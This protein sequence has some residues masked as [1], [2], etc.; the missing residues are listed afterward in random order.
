[1]CNWFFTDPEL[2][3][4]ACRTGKEKDVPKH[5]MKLFPDYFANNKGFQ[6]QLSGNISL[7]LTLRCHTDIVDIRL[8]TRCLSQVAA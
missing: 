6:P 8:A 3:Y 4:E 1:M 7:S 2:I 5:I